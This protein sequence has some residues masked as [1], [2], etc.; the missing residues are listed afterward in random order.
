MK[1]TIHPITDQHHRTG[2]FNGIEFHGWDYREGWI[3]SSPSIGQGLGE[4]LW[5]DGTVDVPCFH[6]VSPMKPSDQ[7]VV[8]IEVELL[9][10]TLGEKTAILDIFWQWEVWE[11]IATA[12]TCAIDSLERM[13]D[14]SHDVLLNWFR[15]ARRD[16]SVLEDIVKTLEEN[17]YT[18]DR[19][20]PEGFGRFR[21]SR[22]LVSMF[23]KD[24]QTKG[25]VVLVYEHDQAIFDSSHVFKQVGDIVWSDRLGYNRGPVLRIEKEQV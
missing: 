12:G 23:R 20:G 21:D 2:T 7:S 1:R 19:V 16:P 13:L 4:L 11:P 9:E 24:D 8:E 10:L 18:V 6:S 14:L 17:G 15:T 22:R 5:V 25:H 3:I